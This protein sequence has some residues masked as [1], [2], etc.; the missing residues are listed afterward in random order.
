M[1][2]KSKLAKTS[3]VLVIIAYPVLF[4]VILV[5]FLGFN[6]FVFP[7]DFLFLIPAFLGYARDILSL[8]F[9]IVALV[10]IKKNNLLG[11]KTA[12]ISLIAS[13]SLPILFYAIWGW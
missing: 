13:I 1:S 5:D 2:K 8:I 7:G 10:F 6:V 4:S 9:S 3:L 11:K 12:I